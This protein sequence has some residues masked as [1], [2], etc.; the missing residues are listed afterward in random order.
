MTSCRAIRH[1]LAPIAARTVSSRCARDAAREK[2]VRDVGA[3][4]QQHAQH[5]GGE[6]Q[7]RRAD[8]GRHLVHHAAHVHDRRAADAEEQVRRH[9]PY[10]RARRRRALGRLLRRDAGRE[11][12][13]RVEHAHQPRAPATASGAGRRTA[14]GVQINV[15]R[16]G[17]WN[18]G[19][20][21]PTIANGRLVHHHAAADDR[22]V[23]AEALAPAAVAQHD[24]AVAPVAFLPVGRIA[25]APASRR[26]SGRGSA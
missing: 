4:D 20:A 14:I 19:R 10:R 11:P 18:P 3:R 24:H 25:R 21:T 15:W 1:A 23:G 8:G 17:N 26:S 13:V 2:Q 12:R 6:H 5:P 9:R 7:Q 22:R 16:S